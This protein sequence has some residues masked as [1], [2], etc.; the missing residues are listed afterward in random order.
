MVYFM[1]Q[2][3][4]AQTWRVSTPQLQVAFVSQK[5]KRALGATFQLCNTE[6]LYLSRLLHGMKGATEMLPCKHLTQCLL[7]GG[8]KV[9]SEWQLP[10]WPLL[11]LLCF[12][13]SPP[14]GPDTGW[15]PGQAVMPKASATPPRLVLGTVT[16]ACLAC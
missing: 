8:Q 6:Q 7:L 9:L 1:F 14:M 2:D 12:L 15:A 13:V 16:W 4:V 3:H 10:F 11:F 5:R